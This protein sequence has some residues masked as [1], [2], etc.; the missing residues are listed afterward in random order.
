MSKKSTA[1]S[2]I[3]V[4]KR[5]LVRPVQTEEKTTTSG[6]YIPDTAKKEKPERGEVVAIGAEELKGVAIGDVVLFSKYGYDE[7]KID[8]EDFYVIPHDNVLAV[9]K[10]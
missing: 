8:G 5:I 3:P 6:L 9:T 10:K 2:F 1:A 4:G 7:V